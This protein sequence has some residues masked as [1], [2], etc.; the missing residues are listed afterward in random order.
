MCHREYIRKYYQKYMQGEAIKYLIKDRSVFN[1]I[2]GR[3]TDP[4]IQASA[5]AFLYSLLESS[6]PLTCAFTFIVCTI[7]TLN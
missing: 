1:W 6:P 3:V 7:Y 5:P 4:Q 2:S